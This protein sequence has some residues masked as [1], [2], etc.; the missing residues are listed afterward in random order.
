MPEF[1]TSIQRA[2]QALQTAGRES[3]AKEVNSDAG[4]QYDIRNDMQN[5]A[6]KPT[7]V[8][9]NALLV[10]R[11]NWNLVE[12]GGA[13][14][15]AEAHKLARENVNVRRRSKKEEL[16][17]HFTP[18]A[19][20]G[21]DGKMRVLRM[22]L[23]NRK[24]SGADN[25]RY[26]LAESSVVK[27]SRT[28]A[29]SDLLRKIK[30]LF[31]EEDAGG[32]NLNEASSAMDDAVPVVEEARAS[33]SKVSALGVVVP[34]RKPERGFVVKPAVAKEEIAGGAVVPPALPVRKIAAGKDVVI[35][36][37]KPDILKS[38][39]AEPSSAMAKGHAQAVKIR[40]GMHKGKT[41]LVIEVT[42]P[43][44]Y[45]VAIDHVRNV[46]RVKIE[47]TQWAMPP[48]DSFAQS[49]LLGTYIARQQADGSVLFEVRLGK[50]SKILDTVMMR[51][52][53]S[54]QHRIVIDLKE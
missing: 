8:N 19:K 17:A 12:Q 39:G 4:T 5:D 26:D 20:S 35:P 25:G 43:V 14:D 44:E 13:M 34:E 37:A 1:I 49:K 11:G 21:E 47:N 38:A 24:D 6:R 33:A 52:N 15:P 36:R 27:P 31:G 42:R 30:S 28:V 51:P 53:L 7:N 40:S 2:G 9:S 3:E 18:D 50:Q 41:R 48:Q 29:E 22:E 10:A 54:S 16:S 32:K 46:L 45:K 23:D